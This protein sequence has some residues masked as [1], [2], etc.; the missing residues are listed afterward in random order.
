[1]RGGPSSPLGPSRFP[2]G[3]L[4]SRPDTSRW[5]VKFNHGY[6]RSQETRPAPSLPVCAPTE[7][8]GLHE[9]YVHN[10]LTNINIQPR[11]TSGARDDSNQ[12]QK[13]SKSPTR[14]DGGGYQLRPVAY[15]PNPPP[16]ESDDSRQSW[17]QGDDFHSMQPSPPALPP[18]KPPKQRPNQKSE[19]A[20]DVGVAPQLPPLYFESHPKVQQQDFAYANQ[21]VQTGPPSSGN[22]TQRQLH[23]PLTQNTSQ[24]RSYVGSPQLVQMTRPS[25]PVQISHPAH[26]APLPSQS[27]PKP[28]RKPPPHLVVVPPL[29]P[30]TRR[31]PN[32]GS[33]NFIGERPS[34]SIQIPQK[35]TSTGEDLEDTNNSFYFHSPQSSIDSAHEQSPKAAAI[36]TNGMLS[37]KTVSS[38]YGLSSAS[39]LGF[40]GPSDWERFGD[41]DAEEVDDLDLYVSSKP[42]TAELPA[43]ASP[44]EELHK[45][46]QPSQEEPGSQARAEQATVEHVPSRQASQDSRS[47]QSNETV[48]KEHQEPPKTLEAEETQLLQ[49]QG[50]SHVPLSSK[51]NDESFGTEHSIEDKCES[52]LPS[53]HK[54]IPIASEPTHVARDPITSEKDID[55]DTLN[56]QALEFAA[57]FEDIGVKTM[58]LTNSDDEDGGKFGLENYDSRTRDA[59][60]QI[61]THAERSSE[62]RGGS[63]DDMQADQIDN[64]GMGD[65]QR[66]RDGLRDTRDGEHEDGGE[67]IIISLHIPETPEELISGL[68]NH[69]H[70]SQERAAKDPGATSSLLGLSAPELLENA[71][72]KRHSYFPKS[73]EMEDPY[74]NLDAWAKASLN[75][76]VKMLHEERQADTDEQKYFIFTNFTRRE[77]KLRAVLYDMDDE[78]EQ[79][80][81][82][83]P[84]KRTPLKESTS[85]LTLR[86]SI[87]SKALPALP[88]GI[89]HS[90]PLRT[91]E[92]NKKL[93]TVSRP[94]DENEASMQYRYDSDSRS[95]TPQAASGGQGKTSPALAEESFVMVDSPS[96]EQYT[97]GGRP[98]LVQSNRHD[99]SRSLKVTPSLTSLRDALNVVGT[100]TT[101]RVGKD[102]RSPGLNNPLGAAS[103]IAE[104]KLSDVPRSN[105]VPLP[106]SADSAKNALSMASEK[107]IHTPFVY[108]EGRPY[109]GDKAT[110]RQSIYQPFSTILRQ[111]SQ[112][113]TS[114]YGEP[115]TPGASTFKQPIRPDASEQ[116]GERRA[117]I[118]QAQVPPAN[119]PRQRLS[120]L[121]PLLV[122]VPPT[123]VLRLEPDQL[124][125][126]RQKIESVPDEFSFIRETVIAWDKEMKQTQEIY[127]QERHMRQGENE[128]RIDALFNENEIGYGDISELETE[129]KRSEAARKAEEDR[130]EYESFVVKVFEVVWARLHYE[131]DQLTPL[132]DVCVQMLNDATAGKE[133]FDETGDRVP[134]APAMDSLLVLYQKL[135]V[136]HQ[137]AFEAVL[138]RDRRLK[139]TEVAPWYSSGN[140]GKVKQIDKRFEDAEK[141]AILEFCGQRDERANLLMDVL[142]QN[143]LRG[144][145]SNQDYMESVM[146]AVRRIALDVAL[147]GMEQNT[148]ISTHEILKAKTIT[149]AL[150]Q[151]SEQIVQ[152]FHVADMLL[153]SA[154]YE[155]SVASARLASADPN[156]FQRLREAKAMEDLKLVKD[157]EHRMSLIRG[158]TSRTHD[159]IS[160]LLSLLGSSPAEST[161]PRSTSAPA[162]PDR[163][164]RL[165]AALDEAKRRNAQKG[166]R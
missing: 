67:D 83:Q 135:G 5:G 61:T 102:G 42:K 100:L 75:R 79:E 70:D 132:Y 41:Y 147:G 96:T 78:H 65:D 142:D 134:V 106:S 149:A 12:F 62:P 35:K 117:S 91:K 112:R 39:A 13:A 166:V 144:V 97:P 10:L 123:S 23:S 121:E 116:G 72:S 24:V 9:W 150:A 44:V 104:L 93:E 162:D 7:S 50:L 66:D 110:N 108:K 25:P 98:T 3:R 2:S 36:D 64:V 1:M 103:A 33:N 120:I 74:A 99:S 4:D 146:Q 11:P 40:G 52:P 49:E 160:K 19:D 143:T 101:E 53:S 92:S 165:L 124:I 14:D 87:R 151:S 126:T 161:P 88:P 20:Q 81:M 94:L 77:T 46:S 105:S 136:R 71:L 16:E 29:H 141:K 164:S 15:D 90:A 153:N 157:L 113:Q 129:F 47:D 125:H 27:P 152:T 21:P 48:T 119:A 54:D 118:T 80:R 140:I 28:T 76:Y 22:L 17:Q 154:D 58:E 38:D 145:G 85:I 37:S 18:P 45:P 55:E 131:M 122:V 127:D 69:E 155:A 68:Q 89:Q 8:S 32:D 6:S 138:E 128:Q 137:K 86:P 107:P 31:N 159:E 73:V 51:L 111:G 163:E 56:N 34:Q 30:D 43:T 82:D 115:P 57:G 156:A 60:Q 84:S 139:K 158:D 63:F 109:E 114:M 59:E 133:M 95:T 26:H 148:V 130:F